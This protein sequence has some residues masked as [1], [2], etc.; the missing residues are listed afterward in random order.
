M[1]SSF[2]WY[3]TIP[4]KFAK[5]VPLRLNEAT[6]AMVHNAMSSRDDLFAT[7]NNV[8]PL[9]GVLV[10]GYRGLMLDLCI[11]DITMGED[12]PNAIKGDWDKVRGGRDHPNQLIDDACGGARED[13]FGRATNTG[14]CCPA[15]DRSPPS[16]GGSTWVLP[17]PHCS[18]LCAFSPPPP[19]PAAFRAR[20]ILDSATPPAMRGSGIA[21]RYASIPSLVCPFFNGI[22]VPTPPLLSRPTCACTA[23]RPRLPPRLSFFRQVLGNIKMFL[24]MNGNKVLACVRVSIQPDFVAFALSVLFKKKR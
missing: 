8:H 9:K 5:M 13:A 10:A 7:Y 21:Q 23:H 20:I 12:I 15:R 2:C 1:S 4:T 18:S 16:N 6:F 11:C 19:P 14:R 17:Y 3:D 24:D 22:I